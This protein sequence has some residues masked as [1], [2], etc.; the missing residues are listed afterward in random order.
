MKRIDSFLD[1]LLIQSSASR[2]A[3]FKLSP[4]QLGA[5]VYLYFQC[6][7][8]WRTQCAAELQSFR[9][10]DGTLVQ[11]HRQAPLVAKYVEGW[12]WSSRRTYEALARRGYV[13]KKICS[14]W[15]LEYTL[16]AEG[17]ELASQ[18]VAVARVQRELS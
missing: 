18:V 10:K 8:T 3:G 5:L 12:I 9:K 7:A 14:G 11:F 17:K 1:G 2:L 15:W 16:T 4:S 6:S 13:D